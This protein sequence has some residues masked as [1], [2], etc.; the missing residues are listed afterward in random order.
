MKYK[1]IVICA[2]V[3]MFAAGS[4]AIANADPAT[5]ALT[6]AQQAKLAR[7]QA[8]FVPGA[9]NNSGGYG[10]GKLAE[11]C[12]GNIPL[13]IHPSMVALEEMKED[14]RTAIDGTCQGFADSVV[15][16]CG[17]EKDADPVVKEMI[18]TNV[19]RMVCKATST[20]SEVDT[21]TGQ[22]FSL[23][24]GVLTYLVAAKEGGFHGGNVTDEGQKFL[25]ANV[26]SASGL[27]IGG[28]QL[29]KQMFENLSIPKDTL[30][31]GL[32]EECGI[33][34][35]VAIDEK[36]PEH[37]SA[38]LGHAPDAACESG[39]QVIYNSCR[40]TRDSETSSTVIKSA[41]KKNLKGISCVYSDNESIAIRPG[42][43][44]ELGYSLN[45]PRPK[46]EGHSMMST[47]TYYFNWLKANIGALGSV[48]P[49]PA[50]AAAAPPASS[51]K[52]T[53]RTKRRPVTH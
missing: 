7:I 45:A 50:G 40:E 41:A 36:L 37:F 14:D 35:T 29:R 53:S 46:F 28:Q 6:P 30:R 12:G 15:Y 17:Y 24:N 52:P 1:I 8:R 20:A 5:P 9:P 39:M 51:A 48:G 13:Q 25:K 19:K 42:G 2:G 49:A 31:K 18:R 21:Y 10:Y 32:K 34:L 27:S 4:G 22:K 3:A 23:E 33:D 47:E 38:H 16:L 11:F 43:I 44:L 26:R